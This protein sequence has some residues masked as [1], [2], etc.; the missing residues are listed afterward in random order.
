M[1][2]SQTEGLLNTTTTIHLFSTI[3]E[4]HHTA[5]DEDCAP[6]TDN[7]MITLS[8]CVECLVYT[9]SYT[10]NYVHYK[11]YNVHKILQNIFILATPFCK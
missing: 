10:V 9:L 7:I 2:P 8:T 11:V 6:Y 3:L 5:N 4:I 1:K